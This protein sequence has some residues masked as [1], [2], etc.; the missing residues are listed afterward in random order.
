MNVK[1]ASVLTGIPTDT[2]RYYEKE[3]LI[4]LIDRNISGNREI[5][6]KI[7]RRLT[8]AKQMRAAGMSVKSLKEYINL[9]DD[10]EDNTEQQKN[11]LREQIVNM[12]EKRDDITFALNHLQYKLEHY[13][14]HMRATEEELH[15]LENNAPDIK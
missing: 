4:P 12:E 8:F 6:E 14:D 15:N 9:V 2:I 13:E 7:I 11:L 3:G 1:E 5:D 10:L